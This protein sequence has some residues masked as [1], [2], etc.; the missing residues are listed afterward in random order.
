MDKTDRD[1]KAGT[2]R[3]RTVYTLDGGLVPDKDD[4]K[5]E[6]LWN[7]CL[8]GKNVDAIRIMPSLVT[9]YSGNMLCIS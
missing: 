9:D 1:V 8:P 5:L 3:S 4:V 2:R 7:S 6:C